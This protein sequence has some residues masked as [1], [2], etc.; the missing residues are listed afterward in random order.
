MD[1]GNVRKRRIGISLTFSLTPEIHNRPDPHLT[2]PLLF[3][4]RHISGRASPQE[5]APAYFSAVPGP[6]SA[7]I[8]V[9]QFL[10]E[11]VNLMCKQ[12]SPLLIVSGN[13]I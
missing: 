6:V 11:A 8:S 5:M 7:Q 9:I 3:L 1:I 4:L 12:Y 13:S 2:E 10:S